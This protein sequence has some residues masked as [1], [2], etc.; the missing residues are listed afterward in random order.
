MWWLGWIHWHT[1]TH[2]SRCPS[3]R[4]APAS[5][6]YR[7]ALLLSKELS[8]FL[9]KKL[10]Q[11]LSPGF[12]WGIEDCVQKWVCGR[13]ECVFFR[14]RETACA[15]E[16]SRAKKKKR[17]SLSWAL[18]CQDLRTDI[19]RVQGRLYYFHWLWS[20]QLENFGGFYCAGVS[21]AETQTENVAPCNS[22]KFVAV[23]ADAPLG[24][25]NTDHTI[26]H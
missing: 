10:I 20:T 19:W 9:P 11:H 7:P 17:N 2:F 5:L 13:G 25:C 14:K 23:I 16:R 21:F 26:P 4:R 24:D 12:M 8:S 15:S 1:C 3:S 22:W 18:L 6:L